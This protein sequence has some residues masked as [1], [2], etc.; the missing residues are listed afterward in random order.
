MHGHAR[1]RGPV[2]LH[3]VEREIGEPSGPIAEMRVE[4][5]P[6]SGPSGSDQR[7]WPRLLGYWWRCGC[8]IRGGSPYVWRPCRNPETKNHE[9]VASEYGERTTVP[10]GYVGGVNLDWMHKKTKSSYESASGWFCGESPVVVDTRIGG[11]SEDSRY[12]RTYRCDKH[13]V[14]WREPVHE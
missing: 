2:T 7:S 12:D 8:E 13:D 11:R 14:I 10:T 4:W 1:L 9:R 6:N 3:Q 5:A